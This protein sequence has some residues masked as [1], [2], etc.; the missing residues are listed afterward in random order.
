MQKKG[1]SPTPPLLEAAIFIPREKL[2]NALCGNLSPGTILFI[3]G[4]PGTGKS[5]LAQQICER[6][7]ETELLFDFGAL[8]SDSKTFKALFKEMCQGLSNNVYLDLEIPHPSKGTMKQNKGGP[9]PALLQT[10]LESGI[11]IFENCQEISENTNML[12]TLAS[13]I[14]CFFHLFV[15]IFVSRT[16]L[17]IPSFARARLEG[18]LLDIQEKELCFDKRE[19][20]SFL[21]GKLPVI[22][23]RESDELFDYF[24]GWPAGLSLFCLAVHNSS[25]PYGIS[26]FSKKLLFEYVES[27][28]WS[29][30]HQND[31]RALS[32]AGLAGFL[33]ISFLEQAHGTKA[34]DTEPEI[35]SFLPF[36]K[37]SISREGKRTLYPSRLFLDFLNGRGS[38][39]FKKSEVCFLHEKAARIL[40][41]QGEHL[42]A[43]SHFARAGKPR[44]CER[45]IAEIAP[46]TEGKAK[47]LL[48]VLDSL[49]RDYFRKN[50]LLLIQ[51]ADIALYSGDFDRAEAILKEATKTMKKGSKSW[52]LVAC[53]LCEVLLLLGRT[54]SAAELAREIGHRTGFMNR[55]KVEAMLFEAIACHQLCLFDRCERLWKKITRLCDTK[56]LPLR[57]E[58]RCYLLAPKAVFFNLERGQFK[59]SERLLD[60]AISIF[61]HK[62]PRNRLSWILLFKGVVKYEQNQLSLALDWF[63]KAVEASESGNRS[64]LAVS[65]AFKALLLSKLGEK[66]RAETVC[67]TAQ[68]EALCD[69]TLWAQVIVLLTKASLER[70]PSRIAQYLETAWNLS[71]ER[72]FVL[73]IAMTAYMAF[74][75]RKRLGQEQHIVNTYLKK[76]IEVSRRFKVK[77]REARLQL[78]LAVTLR[79]RGKDFK[80]NI[81]RAIFLMKQEDLKFLLLSDPNIDGPTVAKDALRLGVE[82]EFLSQLFVSSGTEGARRLIGLFFRA[83]V[84]KKLA[85]AKIWQETRFKEGIAYINSCIESLTS[86]RARIRLQGAVEAL[87]ALPPEPLHIRLLGAFELKVGNR[88]VPGESWK[89]KQARD[90]F[91]VLCLQYPFSCSQ[92]Q[93]METFWPGA[94]PSKARSS[95]WAEISYMRTQLEPWLGKGP[96]KSSSYI[97]SSNKT[98][99]LF[100]PE[101]STLDIMLFKREIQ[102]AKDFLGKGQGIHAAVCLENAVELYREDLLLEDLYAPWC[103]GYREELTNMFSRALARL[104]EIYMDKREIE[105]CIHINQ[106]R[107]DVDQLDEDAYLTIM[108]CHLMLGKDAKAMETYNLCVKALK[109]GLD[110]EPGERLRNL[111]E[112]IE[113]KQKRDET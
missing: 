12:D 8:G 111:A 24:S 104:G 112:K 36:F 93:L 80:S 102:R 31:K 91:K 98:Y 83:G 55:Y 37:T 39:E 46:K 35:F 97:I 30:L 59:E 66:K 105:K 21:K 82:M 44:E 5:I 96:V 48:S 75:L 40:E 51:K 73:P 101:G 27:E 74:I 56:I 106:K 113:N 84:N 95:L 72:G 16:N 23:A 22:T 67:K 70:D 94:A 26:Y 90:I 49:P 18:R 13:Y 60:H 4:G 3:R 81:S 57:H 25:G 41:D 61:T 62:D 71:N 63:S 77:H 65:L 53:R 11:L 52:C 34:E 10:D 64:T 7:G 103:S 33:D 42:R 69:P 107:L 109:E 9:S 110:M 38:K 89:R 29:K 79:E 85:I 86:K 99:R 68:M 50:P 108:R 17:K 43:I 45:V 1:E 15:F 47:D 32:L 28:F 14:Q 78:Y 87:S 100:L 76:A 2:L 58:D 20:L 88:L 54:L 6:I 92:E 19:T